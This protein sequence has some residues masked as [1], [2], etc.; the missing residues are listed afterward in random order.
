M[1]VTNPP[2]PVTHWDTMFTE[3][4]SDGEPAI[5]KLHLGQSFTDVPKGHTFYKFIERILHKGVTTGCTGTTYCP[6]DN[7][8]RLQMALFIAR[9]QAGGDANIPVAGSA[10]GNPYNCTGGGQSQ[11]TDIDPTNP[12]CR[13]VHYI[14]STGVTTGCITTPPRQYCPAD[15]VSRGQMALFIARG[16]AGSDAAV[17]L[18]YGPDPV[19]ARSY[20]CNPGTPNLFFT[21]ITTSDIFCRHVHFLWAKDVISG[22]PDGTFGPALPLPGRHGQVS[23]RTDST[24]SSRARAIT[25]IPLSLSLSLRE[26]VG[27]RAVDSPTSSEQ[28]RP[29]RGGSF[30]LLLLRRP[31]LP[32]HDPGGAGDADRAAGRRR[33]FGPQA[34]PHAH[35]F[36]PAR[37]RWRRRA[38]TRCP[39]G[40]RRESG[41]P[42]AG[43]RIFVDAAGRERV[44]RVED[45]RSLGP[46]RR[47]VIRPSRFIRSRARRIRSYFIEA[48]ASRVL[49]PRTRKSP[50]ESAIAGG[51]RGSRSPARNRT[52]RGRPTRGPGGAGR[53][54]VGGDC[55][56]AATTSPSRRPSTVMSASLSVRAN[57]PSPSL[58]ART[59]PSAIVCVAAEWNFGF[60]REIAHAPACPCRSSESGLGEPDLRR[61]PPHFGFGG[62]LFGN[63]TPRDFPRH[64]HRR[65][66]RSSGLSISSPQEDTIRQDPARC[67]PDQRNGRR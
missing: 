21:D 28:S 2:R 43:R 65:T 38:A 5:R 24:C 39:A 55:S 66:R 51:M 16:V 58:R 27:V 64:P 15:N 32:R 22:F 18:T 26:R 23:S 12:F 52:G 44:A 19:T 36:A 60:R 17:P 48:S 25:R 3:T 56:A 47:M 10:Q 45:P 9:A 57:T 41:R 6:D 54:L 59:A 61:D 53:L 8:F 31:W 34:R 7:V 37:H 20:S 35:V 29:G 62:K 50:P 14:F 46:A 49:S 11:F 33:D 4:L 1:S 30:P 67:H 13:H 40:N 63:P 42:G